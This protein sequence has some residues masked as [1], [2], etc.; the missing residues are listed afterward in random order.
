MASGLPW[1][2]ASSIEHRVWIATEKKVLEHVTNVPGPTQFRAA[3][4][5]YFENKY[6]ALK[7]SLSLVWLRVRLQG[8]LSRLSTNINCVRYRETDLKQRSVR[9][10]ISYSSHKNILHQET[11]CQLLLGADLMQNCSVRSRWT[12]SAYSRDQLVYL[13][14]AVEISSARSGSSSLRSPEVVFTYGDFPNGDGVS[15]SVDTIVNNLNSST[16]IL[17]QGIRLALYRTIL[18]SYV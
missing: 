6:L 8:I 10:I 11:V 16:T 5:H 2:W 1:R 17:K 14:H 12:L 3:S 4:Y 15:F 7:E 18:Y 13:W 9:G